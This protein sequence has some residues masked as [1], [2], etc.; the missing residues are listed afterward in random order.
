MQTTILVTNQQNYV[1][2]LIPKFEN[3]MQQQLINIA[4]ISHIAVS[5]RKTCALCVSA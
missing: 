5:K 1:K 4:A 2:K 3:F